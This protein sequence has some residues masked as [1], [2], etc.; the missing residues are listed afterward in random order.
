M[1]EAG[2]DNMQ[3]LFGWFFIRNP[4]DSVPAITSG[5]G[6][7]LEIRKSRTKTFWQSR[8]EWCDWCSGAG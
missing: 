3:F 4:N 7:R 6:E 5:G 2:T 1:T 8:C